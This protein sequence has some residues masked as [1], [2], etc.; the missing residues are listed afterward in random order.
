LISLR[1]L[2][3]YTSHIDQVKLYAVDSQGIWHKC[4]LIVAWH[5]ELGSVRQLLSQDDE[6][7]V[8]LNPCERIA[9]L[10]FTR[11]WVEDIQLFIFEL[12]GYNP[13]GHY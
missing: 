11:D 4:S 2:D 1:E 6:L 13:K 5:N 9:L 12:N 10:F 8:D 7:R 3:N